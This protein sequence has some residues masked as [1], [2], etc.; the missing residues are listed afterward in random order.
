LAGVRAI[1]IGVEPV[2]PLPLPLQPLMKLIRKNA[3]MHPTPSFHIGCLDTK[4]TPR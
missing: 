2:L 3:K 1:V 4:V